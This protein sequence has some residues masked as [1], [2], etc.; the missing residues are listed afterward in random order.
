LVRKVYPD[1][2]PAYNK[3]W[4]AREI[5][6]SYLFGSWSGSYALLPQLLN[7]IVLS[8]PGSKV[9]VYSNPLLCVSVRQFSRAEWAFAPCI[10]DLPYLRHII[11]ID[12]SFLKGRYKGMLFIVVDYGAENQLMSLAFG[13][14][15]VENIEN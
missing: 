8:N 13:L 3:L 2:N 11:S 12:A 15:E 1:V 10:Q 9:I 6:I 5:T 4:C 14:A 7:A